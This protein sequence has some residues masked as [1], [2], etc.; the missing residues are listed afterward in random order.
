MKSQRDSVDV[1]RDGERL[2]RRRFLK[3][4][5][6]AAGAVSVAGAAHATFIEP[7]NIEVTRID[8]PIKN[9]PAPFHGFRM[10]QMTDIHHGK[11]ISIDFVRHAVELANREKPDLFL[12]TGDYVSHDVSCIKP[13]I[14]AMGTLR[15]PHGR[16]AIL[17]N[18][19]YWVSTHNTRL[20]L[21]EENIPDLTN[22]HVVIQRGGAALC[23]GGVGDLWCDSQNL[24]RTFAGAPPGAPRIL[25]SH[26]P[27]FAEA[28]SPGWKVD[29]M[30]AG[31]THG[32]QIV[33]P[34]FGAPV[35]PSDF[36][37]KYCS[38]LVHGP[39]CPVYVSRGIGVI[40]PPV[41]INCRPE[42]PVFTLRS[43]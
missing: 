34:Y 43:A 1:Q 7:H 26:N 37:Q 4:G 15:A 29:I 36:G 5:I 3:Y 22:S 21:R 19:D 2:S 42:I 13:S 27:D 14:G 32:G 41:R 18:H 33:L 11:Y 23:V 35:V 12:L 9:L 31:H 16:V 20:R 40:T 39:Q 8:I 6:A 24:S 30:I 10:V 28:I 25:L 38:G 17:G